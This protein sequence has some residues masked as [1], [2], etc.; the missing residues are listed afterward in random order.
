MTEFVQG[1]RW[2]VDSEPELGLGM[3][4]SIETR[5]VTLYFPENDSER[6]YALRDAPLTRLILESGDTLEH[7]DD[8]QMLIT[9]VHELN[10]I[11]IYEVEGDRMVPETDLADT[12]KRNNPIMRLITGQTDHPN[13]FSFRSSLDKGIS[14]IWN[15]NLNGLLGTRSTLLP[16]QLYVAKKAT[17]HTHVRALLADEVGLGK[18]IEAGLIVNRLYHQ[19]RAKRILISVPEALQAQWLVELIRRFSIHCELYQDISHDFS[20]GQVHLITHKELKNDFTMA[21]ITELDWDMLVVDEAHHLDSVNTEDSSLHWTE[22]AHITPHL[23]LMTATPEQLGQNAHFGRLQLLDAGRFT[24]F[25]KYQQ[26][27]ANF[28]T[29]TDIARDLNVNQVTDNTIQGLSELGISWN[30]DAQEALSALLDRHGT[31]RVV[32]RNTRKGVKG[33]HD[34]EANFEEFDSETEREKALF[35]F[36]KEHR[37]EKV[38]LITQTMEAAKELAQTLWHVY[39][40]EATAFHEGLDLIERDRA[41]AHFADEEDGAQILVCSEIGGEGRNFQFCHHLILWDLPNHPDVLEQRI[42][43]LDRIGQ[44]QTIQ[45][46]VMANANSDDSLKFRWYQDALNCLEGMQPAAGAVHE[47]YAKQWFENPSDDLL[48]QVINDIEE[49]S[50]QLENGRDILLELNS[51]RQ[52]EATEIRD[53]I[54]DIEFE[55]PLDVVEMAANLL[56]LHFEA[57][58]TGIYELIPSSNMLIP[59]LPGIPE[60]G[61]T[62]TFRRDKA[63]ERE[64]ILFISWEHPFIQGLQ[65]IL[66]GTDIGQASIAL[67]ETEQVPAGQL[68]LETQWSVVLPEMH[69]HAMKPHLDEAL[70]RTLVLEGGDKDLANVL[71]EENLQ[72]Q[73]KTLPVKLARKMV[74]QAKDRINPLYDSS[75]KHAKMRFESILEKARK[76]SSDFN[77]ARIERIKYL[78]SVNPLVTEEDVEKLEHLIKV[79]AK[80]W[81]NCEFATSGV[82]MILCAPPGSL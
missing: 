61:A 38:L 26:E 20:M 79:E 27:E 41:A 56:N 72:E 58:S 71:T 25:E 66:S 21:L 11:V 24:S 9:K 69:I 59:T 7:R 4:Q 22:L 10:G 16:H 54:E 23:L 57:L 39:G 64:D 2:L 3:V 67:L 33:F 15:Q 47:K 48:K 19:G 40:A 28:S 14:S 45:I 82:R 68:L 37:G 51:C 12:V 6:Q 49:L 60:G 1:Q 13:W 77:R 46:H 73:I 17:E 35:K 32:Y 65:D 34:R 18:T 78:A 70:Y 29:L 81:D 63:L 43:R 52:P 62:I 30:D 44:D 55:H 31:G 5:A 75:Q 42:G 50:E 74:R 36:L 76:S 8:G 53:A 80:A